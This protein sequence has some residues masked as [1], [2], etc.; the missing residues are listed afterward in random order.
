MTV[1]LT[2]FGA[3]TIAF[4]GKSVVLSFERRTQLLVYLAL[5]RSW[6]ARAELAA[7]LWPDQDSKLANTNLRKALFRLQ[8][9]PGAEQIEVQPGGL[10]FEVRTD[11]HDFEAA[12]R[13]QRIAEALALRCGDLLAG[14]DDDSNEGW[15]GW[16]HFERDRLRSAWRAAAAQHLAGDLDATAAIDLA[17][18][19]LDADPLDEAALRLYMEWLV[20][21]GQLARARQT[22]N[23]FV[24]RLRDELGLEPG[25]ELR[26]LQDLLGATAPVAQPLPVAKS[27]A[28][29]EGFVGRAVELR[30]IAALMAQ[31]DCRLLSVTGPGGIGKTSLARRAVDQLAP[32]FADGAVF[33]PLDD[34]STPEDLGGRIAHELDIALRGRSEPM[35]QVIAALGERHMLLVLDNFEQLVDGARRLEALLIACPRVRII[36]TSRVRLALANE[37]LLPLDGLPCPEEEDQDRLEAFDAARLFVRAAHRVHPELVASAEA[38]AIVDICRQVEGLPLALEL[39]AS[40]TR[41]LSCEAIAAELRQSSELLQAS[42]AARP[43]RHASIETVFEQSWKLLGERERQALARLSVF[44]GGFTPQ[45]ARAVGGVPLPVLAA[46]VDKSLLRKD[47]ARCLM[48]PLVQQFAQAKLEQGGDAETSAVAHSRHFLRYVADATHRVRNADPETLCEL[49]VDFENIRAAWRFAGKHGPGDDLVRAAYSLM[50]YC[51]HRGRRLDGFELLLGALHG[52][53]SASHPE[54][55]QALAAPAA[56]LAF[57]LDRYEEAESL[58]RMSLDVEGPDRRRPGDATSAF[59]AATVLGA[60]CA[61]L[62]RVD[63]ARRWFQQAVDLAKKT[64]DPL[65]MASALDNLGLVTRVVGDLD[66]ALRLYRQALLKHREAGDAGGEAL[67]LNNQGVVHILRREFDGAQAVLRDARQLCERH[68]LPSTRAMVE[69]NLASVAALSGATELAGTHA[70]HALELSDQTG[71]RAIAADAHLILARIATRQGDLATARVELSAALS[72][73]IAIGRPAQLV[74]GVRQFAELLAVHGASDVAARVMAYVLQQPTLVGA[75]R[76]EAERQILSWG[77]PTVTDADWA[78]PPL[79][80]LA[81]RVVAETGQS[82]APL[83][84]ALRG[85]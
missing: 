5:K 34:L 41:V 18:R 61:R 63:E 13:Q 49:D 53:V 36:V 80:E 69:V 55:I 72:V 74:Q 11:V 22:Y 67:C 26:S 29:D 28:I 44:R 24:A 83:I 16:I 45:V 3:P 85:H 17:A 81:Q 42:D 33:V 19:L 8:G 37:W 25:A 10:R 60:T 31:D 64:A 82:Y 58:G 9:L 20:R 7:L 4:G 14:F 75:E 48:H 50:T 23:A 71:Q 27:A 6:V 65:D 77:A 43:A 84:A 56:W 78:G 68:G 66:G 32:G 12:V 15:S 51:D 40:W 39:A 76:E 70:R 52:D 47:G 46:L 2:L 21:A 35:E 1:G 79:Q 38:S 30:R 62:G 73:S 59:R 57:R 54:L